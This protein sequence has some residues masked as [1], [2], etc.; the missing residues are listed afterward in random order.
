MGAEDLSYDQSPQKILHV[1]LNKES[2]NTAK[3]V[4]SLPQNGLSF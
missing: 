3:L 2:G 1:I 4:F